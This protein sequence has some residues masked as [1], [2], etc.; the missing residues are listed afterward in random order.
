MAVSSVAAGAGR[1]GV[2]VVTITAHY[3]TRTRRHSAVFP[4][5][6]EPFAWAGLALTGIAVGLRSCR[7][8]GE[9]ELRKGL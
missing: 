3:R 9:S 1:F 2:A 5:H 6:S 4:Q 8:R 7:R